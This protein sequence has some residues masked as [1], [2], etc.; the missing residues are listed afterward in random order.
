MSLASFQQALCDLIA[1]PSLC[2]A[3]RAAPDD[4][5]ANYELSARERRRLVEAVWQRGMSTNCSLY[6]SN[7]VTPLYTQLNGTCRSLGDQFGALLDR[8]WNSKSYQ[9]GQF[10]TEAERFAA[11]LR[12][13]IAEGA[14]S[15]PFTADLLEFELALNSLGFAPRRKL[16]GE[17]AH[18][19]APGLDTLCRLHPLARIVAFR[20]EPLALLAAAAQGEL[21]G[22][23]NGDLASSDIPERETLV[24]L[25][26]VGD[27]I[28]VMLL[29]DETCHAFW[30][31]AGQLKLLTPRQA[32]EL[33]DAGLLVPHLSALAG[34]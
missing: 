9:N 1:S 28:S 13:R 16:L 23:L 32:P 3:L 25:N 8:F 15:S 34:G 17:I 27:D 10:Q 20:H 7:R 11:F 14:V 24:V 12:Q 22:D 30:D 33:S 19:P 2:R 6:R 29:A 18:L 4:V 31:G 26:A 21:N 5:M